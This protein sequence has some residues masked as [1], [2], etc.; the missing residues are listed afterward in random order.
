MAFPDALEAFL[1]PKSINFEPIVAKM[2][3]LPGFQVTGVKKST[4]QI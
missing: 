2:L 4:K 1:D 3:D